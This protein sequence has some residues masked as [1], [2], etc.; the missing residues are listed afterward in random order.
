VTPVAGA[1]AGAAATFRGRLTGLRRIRTRRRGF[2]LVRG[3]VEDPTGRLPVVWF[4][5][6]YLTDQAKGNEE[7]L[8]HGPVREAKGGWLELLN[9]SC[10][11]A[12]EAVHSARIAPVYPALKGLGPTVLRRLMDS[13]LAEVDL[14]QMPETLPADLLERHGLPA[15]GEVLESL[16]RPREEDV[17]ALNA[18]RT[19]A[20]HRLVYGELLEM[21][22]T[23]ALRRERQAREPRP[24]RYR[25]GA[26]VLR[27]VRKALPFPLT[28][29]QE[30]VLAE[31]VADLGVPHP[32]HRLLQGDVGSGKTAVAA[33]ALAL[34]VESGFQ[35]AFMAP[36]ELL[37]E[38]HYLSLARLLGGRYR[39]VLLTGGT[40]DS[41]LR[42]RI[43]SGEAQ[44]VVGTHALIQE[45]VELPGLGLA[46]IDEQHRFGVAQRELLR[47]KGARPDVLVMTATPIPRS[48][49]LTAWGDLPVS[50][51]DEMP[52]GRTPVRTEVVP[53][54]RR[55]EI[56]RRLRAAVEAGARAYVVAPHIEESG[57]IAGAGPASLEETEIRVREALAGFPV[58]VLHGRMRAAERERTMRAFAAGEVRALVATTVIE[59]G[60]DVPAAT[61]M[62]I[63]SAER[64]G[65][66]QLHQLRG[67]VGRGSGAS[68]CV[69]IHGRLTAAGRERLAVFAS[70]QDGFE[71]AERDLLLRGPGDVLGTRQAGL[72]PLKMARLPTDWDWLVKARDDARELLARLDEPARQ[73]LAGQAL[74]KAGACASS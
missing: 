66:A 19:P 18:R 59:V 9:P 63:E 11:P 21:Q 26:Q 7:H 51:L 68:A 20:H 49:A 1:S 44:L 67:R 27:S 46:V 2:S 41:G 54:R 16:H 45:G 61:W 31:I 70:T 60:V 57:K 22:V 32:M 69:A 52:P 23:L 28:G 6:P 12:A 3:F 42:A 50:T 37:A 65:L 25:L 62:V 48:L 30:R 35:G 40:A 29:A 64:F 56:Y 33:L 5:R 53:A 36:T 34:A 55:P 74:E 43:A 14:R 73:A 8:L 10:E 39:T 4:N 17:E 47:R 15:L 24:R 38:Q 13:L 72:A 71:I 58:A